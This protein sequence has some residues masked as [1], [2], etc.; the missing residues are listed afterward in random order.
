MRQKDFDDLLDFLRTKKQEADLKNE[1]EASIRIGWYV[2][3]LIATHADTLKTQV[4]LEMLHTR[5]LK[6]THSF[7]RKRG[8][9]RGSATQNQKQTHGLIPCIICE[10]PNIIPE[11][12]CKHWHQAEMRHLELTLTRYKDA[13]DE[14]KT[15]YIRI[16]KEANISN[17]KWFVYG[18]EHITKGIIKWLRSNPGWVNA[19]EF[20]DRIIKGEHVSSLDPVDE[21]EVVEKKE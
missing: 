2:D 12:R 9:P 14:F 7:I 15:E 4:E 17:Q 1:T 10:S 5:V 20:S 11:R 8:R 16:K 19:R 3:E 6:L 21:A 13:N 18:M